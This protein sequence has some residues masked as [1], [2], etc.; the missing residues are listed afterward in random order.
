MLRRSVS[1]RFSACGNALSWDSVSPTGSSNRMVKFKMSR[2]N[3]HFIDPT[4]MDD[5]LLFYT[6]ILSP[7]AYTPIITIYIVNECCRYTPRMRNT[8]RDPLDWLTLDRLGSCQRARQSV[9]RLR[10]M[11]EGHIAISVEGKK[12]RQ[13]RLGKRVNAPCVVWAELGPCESPKI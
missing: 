11:G 6:Y 13:V 5:A 8:S 1:A 7:T 9:L 3:L 10:G 4:Y 2:N 12:G